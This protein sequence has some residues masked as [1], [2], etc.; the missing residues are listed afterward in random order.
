MENSP[1]LPQGFYPTGHH[2]IMP[3]MPSREDCV[4]PMC[5]CLRVQHFFCAH[6]VALSLSLHASKC[7][8]QNPRPQGITLPPHVCSTALWRPTMSLQ[9]PPMPM[10]CATC[11]SCRTVNALCLCHA[12]AWG[13]PP[14]LI[15]CG[16]IETTHCVAFCGV[17]RVLHALCVCVPTLLLAVA[18]TALRCVFILW[19]EKKRIPILLTSPFSHAFLI[20]P[21][22]GWWSQST[23][24][25]AAAH[26]GPVVP[27]PLC[28]PHQSPRHPHHGPG[29]SHGCCPGHE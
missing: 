10:K 15:R 24:H 19:A 3:G 1:Q 16:G 11:T 23:Q 14:T 20:H 25:P 29:S 5:T 13:I 4:Y 21:P 17:H 26:C 28:H 18:L 2:A 22:P 12:T 27:P 9:G 7:R 6:V 8:R